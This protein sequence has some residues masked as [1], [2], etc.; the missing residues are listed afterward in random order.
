MDLPVLRTS[1]TADRVFCRRP[2][3]W[4]VGWRRPAGFPAV[5]AGHLRSRTVDWYR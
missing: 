1:R 5:P 2:A 3:G 4:L